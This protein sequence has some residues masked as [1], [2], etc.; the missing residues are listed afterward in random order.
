MLITSQ[1]TVVKVEKNWCPTCRERQER[2]TGTT[3]ERIRNEKREEE[4]W[5][6]LRCYALW[7]L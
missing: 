5:C 2:V 7:L 6:L 4:E 3:K 1:Y